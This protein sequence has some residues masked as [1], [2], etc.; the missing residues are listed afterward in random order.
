MGY[1]EPERGFDTYPGSDAGLEI[2]PPIKKSDTN[3]HVKPSSAI[4]VFLR[5]SPH[6]LLCDPGTGA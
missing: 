6:S 2:S 3:S 5:F 4:R 1:A